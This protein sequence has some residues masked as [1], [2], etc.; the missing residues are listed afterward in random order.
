[1]AYKKR[2]KKKVGCAT[3][4]ITLVVAVVVAAVGY[5]GGFFGGKQAPTVVDGEVMFHFIDV[6]QADAALI[7]TAE[8]NVL[9]DAGTNAAEDD[10]KAYLD[11]KGIKDIEYAVFTHPHEDHIGGA[12]MVMNNYNVKNVI[13]PEK[14]QTSQTYTKMID[15]IEKSNANI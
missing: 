1:M 13:M 12:D 5:F 2:R 8:G 14:E 7:C 3:T 10:L 11:S 4:V 9:I 6:G 15:A